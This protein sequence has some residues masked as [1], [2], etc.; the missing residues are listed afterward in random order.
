MLSVR[1]HRLFSFIEEQAP[2]DRI[3]R[4]KIPIRRLPQFADYSLRLLELMCLTAA[5]RLTKAQRI[6]EFGTFLGNT[7]LHMAMNS[8]ENTDI[9]TLDADDD[10]L[11]RLNLLDIYY[12]RSQF[13]MEFLGTGFEHKIYPIR[14]D[15]HVYDASR[16]KHSMDLVLIDGDHSREAVSKDTE[17]ALLMLKDE[18]PAC[19]AWHDYKNPLCGGNTEYLDE[20]SRHLPLVHVEDTMVVMY[21]RGYDW[22]A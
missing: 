9:W 6:F 20:L 7:T 12:W 13:P 10:T 19:I 8:A 11:K 14:G 22:A 15:S 5:I 4:M 18:G 2:V 21:L 1:P 16:F 3:T 17:N